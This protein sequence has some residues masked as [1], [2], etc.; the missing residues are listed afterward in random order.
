MNPGL[1]QHLQ[2]NWPLAVI[3]AGLLVYLPITLIRGEFYTNQGPIRKVAEPARYWRWVLGFGGL[4]LACAATL[5][6]SFF[7]AR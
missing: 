7:L 6:A 1:V 3:V 5:L 4:L 2:R